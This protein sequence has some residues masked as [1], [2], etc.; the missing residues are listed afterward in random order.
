MDITQAA[1][2]KVY[3]IDGYGDGGFRIATERYEGAVLVWPYHAPQAWSK[4]AGEL[5]A[6]EDFST[7]LDHKAS[8]ELEIIVIGNGKEFAMIPSSLRAFFKAR[9]IAVELMDTG[10]A[11]RTY[12]ILVSEGRRVAAALLPV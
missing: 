4:N 7:L 12:N 9:G 1:S 3:A 8:Q 10:A 5:Y 2:D 6:P 11:C